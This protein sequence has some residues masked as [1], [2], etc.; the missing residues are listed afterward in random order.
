MISKILS[1]LLLFSLICSNILKAQE[2]LPVT[3][4]AAIGY[5]VSLGSNSFASATSL[6]ALDVN[7]QF[8]VSGKISIGP[9]LRA[10][11]YGDKVQFTDVTG[12]V[13]RDDYYTS[14]LTHWE[15]LSEYQINLAEKLKLRIGL[16]GGYAAIKVSNLYSYVPGKSP[17]GFNIASGFTC[18]YLLSDHFA[19]S[20]SAKYTFSS[21]YATINTGGN[22]EATNENFNEITFS[23]GAV[24]LF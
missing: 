12:Q 18:Q 22:T 1:V 14:I 20:S 19:L 7:A 15:L 21:L 10:G 8:P 24:Y 6:L 13:V 17:K 3:I 11:I 4:S 9:S 2:Q 5:P 16:A 23:L